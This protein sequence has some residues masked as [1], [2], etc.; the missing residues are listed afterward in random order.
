MTDP[1]TTN[2][3]RLLEGC[4]HDKM[5]RLQRQFEAEENYKDEWLADLRSDMDALGRLK[6]KIRKL[7]NEQQ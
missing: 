4:I 3:L 1:I 6:N 2:E 7:I 5:L